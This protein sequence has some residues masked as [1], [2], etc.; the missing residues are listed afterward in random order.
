MES[1]FCC[2]IHFVSFPFL[3]KVVLFGEM[4]ACMWRYFL[5]V[6]FLIPF[7]YSLSFFFV[8]WKHISIWR[9]DAS[10]N[11]VLFQCTEWIKFFVF[12]L[13]VKITIIHRFDRNCLCAHMSV[14]VRTRWMNM[15]F[16]PVERVDDVCNSQIVLYYLHQIGHSRKVSW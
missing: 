1:R 10:K 8:F 13:G 9:A 6:C 11:Y 12:L 15:L 4:L 2:A 3:L 7:F 14:C 16:M 5:S